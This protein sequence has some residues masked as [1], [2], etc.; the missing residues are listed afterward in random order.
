M[1]RHADQRRIDEHAA[2]A[3]DG[4]VELRIGERLARAIDRADEARSLGTRAP[5]CCQ[6]LAEAA[7][8]VSRAA[9]APAS[10]A[11]GSSSRMAPDVRRH[12]VVGARQH[13]AQAPSSR[14]SKRSGSR[15]RRVRMRKRE[16]SSGASVRIGPVGVAGFGTE[17]SSVRTRVG[18]P[19][20]RGISVGRSGSLTRVDYITSHGFALASR[21]L[22]RRTMSPTLNS[23]PLSLGPPRGRARVGADLARGNARRASVSPYGANMHGCAVANDCTF[24]LFGDQGKFV[25]LYAQAIAPA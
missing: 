15:S 17:T 25:S 24:R 1:H 6:A 21:S 11:R 12:E 13:L 22:R 18:T 8:T 14:T 10:L 19:A 23:G 7:M 5:S 9:A 20:S 16:I 4:V 3:A 2:H